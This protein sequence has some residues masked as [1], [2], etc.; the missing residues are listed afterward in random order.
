MM[1]GNRSEIKLNN[2]RVGTAFAI[3]TVTI[4][5][6]KHKEFQIQISL[7]SIVVRKDI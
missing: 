6:V 7:T 3:Y 5:K 1:M 2:G 4:E